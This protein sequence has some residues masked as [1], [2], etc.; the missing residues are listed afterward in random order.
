MTSPAAQ[1]RTLLPAEY[2]GP[3]RRHTP[4]LRVERKSKRRGLACTSC[5]RK[6]VKCSGPPPCEACAASKSECSFE[7]LTDKRRRLTQKAAEKDAE[8]HRHISMYLIDI[9]RSGNEEDVGNLVREM[10][11]ASS[12]DSAFADLRSIISQEKN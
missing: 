3:D 2:R 5:Q 1:P 10:Q 8:I 9:L 4:I 11:A 12:R 7:P 6:R